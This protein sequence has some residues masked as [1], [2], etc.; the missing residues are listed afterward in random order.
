MYSYGKLLKKELMETIGYK[1]EGSG[2]KMG[3]KRVH[4]DLHELGFIPSY[5]YIGMNLMNPIIK[6]KSKIVQE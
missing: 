6:P 1:I 2:F 5:M 3:S 4:L